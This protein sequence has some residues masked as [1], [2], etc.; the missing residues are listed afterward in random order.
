MYIK[1]PA[2]SNGFTS[3]VDQNNSD[4]H[5]IAMGYLV[6][7]QENDVY[8][9]D[10]CEYEVG[11]NIAF[12]TVNMRVTTPDRAQTVYD[13]LG[14]RQDRFSGPPCMIYIPA[15]SRVAL[16]AVKVPFEALVYRAPSTKSTVPCVIHPQEVAT[17]KTGILNWSRFV[18]YV[19]QGNVD[20]HRIVLGE[21]V[22]PSGHWTSY[23]PHK[24]DEDNPPLEK[25][26]EEL[27]LFRFNKP[28]GFAM[29]R[30][31][32]DP[33]IAGE[34]D[35]AFVVK[36]GDFITV[37]RGY[38]S[39]AVAPGYSMIYYFCLSGEERNWDCFQDD[40]RYRWIKDCETIF[41]ESQGRF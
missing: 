34:Y 14:D 3:I 38:H 31:N 11:I 18:R 39:I 10:T 19:I 21:T 8:E 1:S 6:F 17:N 36:D 7:S 27:Y 4:L 35:D 12:G 28:D 23:P 29:I 41:N 22:V 5:N 24:H 37:P 9:M 40:K 20:A 25:R 30:I 33:G 32:S 26:S 13:G 2:Y 15:G 16:R